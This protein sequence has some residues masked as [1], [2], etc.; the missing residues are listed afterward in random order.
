MTRDTEI[1][2]GIRTLDE[3]QAGV[4][5]LVAH[6]LD[7]PRNKLSLQTRLIED[8]N[9]D[10]LELVELMMAIETAFSVTIS[11]RAPNEVY[12]S[13]F[14]RQPF[15]LADLAELVYLQQHLRT[16]NRCDWTGPL[17]TAPTSSS[18]PFAQLGGRLESVVSSE[19][20]YEPLGAAA[21]G[22][23]QFRRR[24]D[25]M[26][27]VL[28]PAAVVEIGDEGPWASPDE[29]PKHLTALDAFLIDAEPVSTVAY[30]RF[31]NSNSD[32]AERELREW[33]VLNEDDRRRRHSLLV[34]EESAWRPLPGTGAFP[35]ILVSWYGANAYSL[36]ANGC[37][38]RNY[39]GES[40]DTG[41]ASASFLPSEAQWEYAARGPISQKYPWGDG[42]PTQARL[43]SDR[44]RVGNRYAAAELPMACVN[45]RL[46][47][48]PFG[49]HH[50]AGNVWQWCRDWYDPDFYRSD[51][52]THRNAL[53]DQPTGVRSERGGSWVGPTSLARSSFRRA[54]P[55]RARG[56]C[57]GFRC[58]GP[59]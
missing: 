33:F 18:A 8:L 4:L 13:V 15:R 5:D 51:Q 29:Q 1:A 28:L 41:A 56:R 42:E 55:P 58:I 54:R 3:L 43:R 36:W 17:E 38:W 52:A 35:M 23:R 46:G 16:P 26:R 10:S 24:T 32:C 45:E 31:L 40:S 9:C 34:R 47:M 59:P 12:K 14:T 25:G 44:H 48:S 50:M 57:L 21:D 53:N 20:L 30:A 22:P 19:T 6:Q 2:P 11:D 27:C 39:R 7:F 49:L 37:D